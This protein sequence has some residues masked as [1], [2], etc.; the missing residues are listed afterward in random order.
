MI[1]LGDEKDIALW[2]VSSKIPCLLV[3][4]TLAATEFQ[5]KGNE[6]RHMMDETLKSV[7]HEDGEGM[8]M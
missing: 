5:N 1:L 4:Q 7:D 2:N 3:Y 8:E 6:K